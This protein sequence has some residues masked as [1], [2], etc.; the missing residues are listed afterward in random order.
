MR[1]ILHCDCNNFY[2][3]VEIAK[4]K[5]RLAGKPLIVC[6][7]PKLRHGIVL[8]KS[9]EAK[10]CGIQTG[11]TI[12]QARK[13]CPDVILVPACFDDYLT[14]SGAF[15]SLCRS[16]SP[17]VEPFG[18][19][20]NWLDITGADLSGDLVASQLR[21][22]IKDILGITLSIGVSSNKVFSKL[23]SDFR[24]PDATTIISPAKVSQKI[25]PL[26]VDVMLYIGRSTSKQLHSMGI[27]T[28]GQLAHTDPDILTH[29]FG[30]IG[31]QIKNHAL[32]IEAPLLPPRQHTAPVKSIGNSS[33]PPQDMHT[34]EQTAVL[35][36]TLCESVSARMHEQQCLGQT[37][38]LTMKDTRFHTF[39][40]QKALPFPTMSLHDI[41]SAALSMLKTHYD[42]HL[43]LRAVGV[44]CGNLLHVEEDVQSLPRRSA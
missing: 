37:I 9:I 32:G 25:W 11:E 36:Y 27:D 6:G 24:K 40:R 4:D 42:F 15:R 30:K 21:T 28:I 38:T 29:T 44:T 14:A 22:A 26:P 16:F 31:I 7:D 12:W 33:T 34:F 23:A 8:A 1:T 17:L 20:E 43:P 39:S 18:L 2:A 41:A 10:R 19:D 3:S 5:K 13:K 35:I